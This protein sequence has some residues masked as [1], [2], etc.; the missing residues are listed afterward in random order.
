M[1]IS[2]DQLQLLFERQ[3]QRFKNSQLNVLDNLRTRLL[4]HPCFGDVT[5]VDKL[6]S[7]LHTELENDRKTYECVDKSLYE[8]LTT[9]NVSEAVAVIHDPPSGPEMF[10]SETCPVA[11]SNPN[12]HEE[13]ENESSSIMETV[14]LDR[15]H[16]SRTKSS[17]E[18]TYWSSLVVLSNMSYFNDSSAFDQICYKNERN[19]SDA[20]NDDQEP[21]KILIDSDYSSDRLSTN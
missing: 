2:F 21:N 17:D 14:E 13:T 4:N 8:S 10:I 18:S 19:L 12:A 15:A 1:V 5:E 6:I 9:S 20:P 11:G 16:H 7:N 3:R